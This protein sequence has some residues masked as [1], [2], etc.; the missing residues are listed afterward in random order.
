MTTMD[1][2]GTTAAHGRALNKQIN[3]W[4][5]SLVLI[6]D[7]VWCGKEGLFPHQFG[8]V[9]IFLSESNKGFTITD[10]GLPGE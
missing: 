2:G 10:L 1:H 7:L 6:G 3:P 4:P 8:P 9:A 5:P